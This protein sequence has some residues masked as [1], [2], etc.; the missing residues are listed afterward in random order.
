M[1]VHVLIVEENPQARA[2]MTRV[3]RESLTDELE[4]S[5][6]ANL[7]SARAALGRQ[8]SSVQ[9]TFDMVLVDLDLPDGDG[10]K[11]LAELAGQAARKV[12]TSLYAD[13][14]HIFPALQLGAGGYLLKEDR[15]EVLVEAL[16]KII[17]GRP[18]VS[19]AI[20]R[21]MLCHFEDNAS[22]KAKGRSPLTEA[23]INVLTHLSKGYS[24]KEIA[25]LMKLKWVSIN[26]HLHSACRKLAASASLGKAAP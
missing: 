8:A 26:D 20:A 18:V 9:T 2:F 3:I 21:R 13:D 6:A 5:E 12:V 14:E 17:Q 15:L 1:S 4:I 11:L 7:E 24:I 19:P 23:E 10:L 25:T 16:Q 22:S